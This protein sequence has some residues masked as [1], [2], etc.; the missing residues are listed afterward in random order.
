MGPSEQTF[1]SISSLNESGTLSSIGSLSFTLLITDSSLATPRT[2]NPSP[3]LG[4]ISKLIMESLP[5]IFDLIC[6]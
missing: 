2:L 4:V 1:T 6:S 5:V 3:R